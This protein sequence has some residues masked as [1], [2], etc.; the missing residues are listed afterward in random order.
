MPPYLPPAELFRQRL[1]EA[2]RR[3][4][5]VKRRSV[6]GGSRH[7]LYFAYACAM[8]VSV[9]TAKARGRYRKLI[10]QEVI[11][12]L[13]YLGGMMQDTFGVIGQ[14]TLQHF[15]DLFTMGTRDEGRNA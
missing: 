13:D 2:I 6:R 11:A 5:I 4:D 8:Q 12:E 1:V 9:C 15:D 10:V 3:L 14:S 7:L